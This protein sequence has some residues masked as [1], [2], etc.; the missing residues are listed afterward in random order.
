MAKRQL[1]LRSLGFEYSNGHNKRARSVQDWSL[2]ST[3]PTAVPNT[4]PAIEQDQC[5]S[6]T[7]PAPAPTNAVTASTTYD[8]GMNT[9]E[10]IH[11]LSNEQNLWLLKHALRPESDFKFPTKVEYAKSKSFQHLWLKKY[12]WL[13]YSTACNYCSDEKFHLSK[14]DTPR[15]QPATVSSR[16]WAAAE[17]AAAFMGQMESGHLSIQQQLQ[18]QASMKVQKNFEGCS[19][20][21]NFWWQTEHCPSWLPREHFQW[22]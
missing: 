14:A 19:Q 4:E 18:S 11:V 9:G 12:H 13:A 16:Y 6:I 21:D 1:S 8:L 7:H 2:S 20:D 5:L 3:H 17:D 22:C 15:A 10:N